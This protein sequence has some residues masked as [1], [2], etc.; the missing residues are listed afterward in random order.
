M[1]HA[2]SDTRL[3]DGLQLFNFDLTLSD[4]V[5]NLTIS[6]FSTQCRTCKQNGASVSPCL[7]LID[8][9][10]QTK[11]EKREIKITFNA[12]RSDKRVSWV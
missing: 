9:T 2:V 5:L 3:K 8:K 10:E 12:W 4:L 1:I 6:D 11:K 7:P